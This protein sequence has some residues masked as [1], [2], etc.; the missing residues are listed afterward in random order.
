MILKE[1]IQKD[2]QICYFDST[3]GIL[4]AKYRDSTKQ[5]AIIFKKGTQ[6]V[7]NNISKYTFLRFKTTKSQ[8]KYLKKYINGKHEYTKV[9]SEIDVGNIINEIQDLKTKNKKENIV[10]EFSEKQQNIIESNLLDFFGLDEKGRFELSKMFITLELNL[11]NESN[12]EI[13]H[14]SKNVLRE[15]YFRHE[16]K[17]D[18]PLLLKDFKI[19]MNENNNSVEFEDFFTQ[20]N[21]K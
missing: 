16:K 2:S 9:T 4:V 1:I 10:Y 11:L 13:I 14:L 21:K 8:G 15:L 6:Y 5:M 12:S 17:M 20:F 3:S 18:V 7:Y 19:W